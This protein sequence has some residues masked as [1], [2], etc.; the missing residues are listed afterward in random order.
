LIESNKNK[1]LLKDDVEIPL[2]DPNN[3]RRELFK[4]YYNSSA[5]ENY[6]LF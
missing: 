5:E 2:I 4:Y 6:G 1:Q 3:L